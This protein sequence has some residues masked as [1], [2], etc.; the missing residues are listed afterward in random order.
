[1]SAERPDLP[2]VEKLAARVH[3]VIV[4]ALG[5]FP[6]KYRYTTGERLRG[7]AEQIH[8]HLHLAWNNPQRRISEASQALAQIDLLK[9]RLQLA[10]NLQ[11]FGSLAECEMVGRLVIELGGQ[12]GGWLAALRNKG[13]SAPAQR[14][15]QRARTLSSQV[16]SRIE[17]NP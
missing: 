8:Y 10:E 13:Q 14:R 7:S 17:A 9:V 1:M 12:C 16:A 15:A 3:A 2:D 11:A 4:E 5:R 6:K